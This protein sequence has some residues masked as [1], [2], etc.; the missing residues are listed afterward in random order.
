M[1]IEFAEFESMDSLTAFSTAAGQQLPIGQYMVE[2][3]MFNGQTSAG[4]LKWFENL[5]ASGL[6]ATF[7]EP[8]L[9]AVTLNNNGD[10]NPNMAEIVMVN[11]KDPRSLL[12]GGNTI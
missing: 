8:N 7:V 10:K 2:V 4:Y 12:F 5:E 6:R 3:H 1:D 11:A 9:L